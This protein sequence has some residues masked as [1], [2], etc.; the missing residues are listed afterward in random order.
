MDISISTFRFWRRIVCRIEGESRWT[1]E[2]S[3][4]Q[5]HRPEH[6]R[7][8]K[9]AV[10]RYWRTEIVADDGMDRAVPQGEYKPED[11]LHEIEEAE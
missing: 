9:G 6:I 8:N 10:G 11:I 1:A 3:A 7:P 5:H 4:H 2:G